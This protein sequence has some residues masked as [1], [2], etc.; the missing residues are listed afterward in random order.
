[1]SAGVP[2]LELMSWTD[3]EQLVR[4]GFEIGAHTRTHPDLT[5]L[6]ASRVD[7][8]C[9]GSADRIASELGRRPGSFAYPY[10]RVNAAVAD[11]ARRHFDRSCTTELRAVG[12]DEDTALLPRLDAYYF[13]DAGRLEQ[14]GTPAFRRRLW[15]RARGR[16]LRGALTTGAGFVRSRA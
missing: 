7:E 15:L 1:M 4:D 9:A 14:W 5:G 11:A 3:L 13:R 2:E 6:D 8:E 16:A 10:G 12:Q